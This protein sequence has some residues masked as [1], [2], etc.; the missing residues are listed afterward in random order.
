MQR[1][2]GV[3]DFRASSLYETAPIGGPEGQDAFLN[4][5]VAFTSEEA[6]E[7]IFGELLGIEQTLHRSRRVRWEARTIDLDLLAY[8]D[9]VTKTPT[10]QVPHP[11]MSYRPF[12]LDPA[13]EVAPDWRHPELGLDL[14]SLRRILREGDNSIR[15]VGRYAASLASLIQAQLT[16]Q[17]LAKQDTPQVI[18]KPHTQDSTPGNKLTI[19]IER[20]VYGTAAGPTLCLE[21]CPSD[22]WGSEVRAAIECVWPG[23]GR[24][25]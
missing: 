23:P 1:L 11:R 13:C 14:K 17:S 9:S 15:V 3:T 8:G 2:A 19:G 22:D 20:S 16:D 18:W 6:P 7:T 21:D 10:L 4:A 12:V 24:D 25:S 5:A